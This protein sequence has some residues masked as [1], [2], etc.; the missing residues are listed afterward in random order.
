M[1][2]RKQATPG[3]TRRTKAGVNTGSRAAA[4]WSVW[5]PW[6]VM[7]VLAAGLTAV[8]GWVSVLAATMLGWLSVPEMSIVEPVRL[9]AKL[10][11]L[12][13]GTPVT[14]AAQTISI[15]PLGLSLLWAW[16][17]SALSELATR[18]ALAEL[19]GEERRN[20]EVARLSAVYVVAYLVLVAGVD[21]ALMGSLSWRGLAGAAL[22]ALVSGVTGV[23]R[24][25]RWRPTLLSGWLRAPVW[26]RALP[27]VLRTAMLSVLAGGAVVSVVALLAAEERFLTLH[28]ALSP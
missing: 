12:G 9:A 17:G 4:E 6:P 24:A 16:A 20:K 18:H 2:F 13:H 19:P 3:A 11:L 15:A 8:A 10:W 7:L 23:G 26:I 27:Q 14:I 1:R 5:F 22:L 25:C 21:V 28:N